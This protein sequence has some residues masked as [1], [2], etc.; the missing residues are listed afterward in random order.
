MGLAIGPVSC[1]MTHVRMYAILE[2][3]H[4]WCKLLTLSLE[5]QDELHFCCWLSTRTQMPVVQVMR[6]YVCS[7]CVAYG[8][9]TAE[10]HVA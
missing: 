2:S 4:A 6:G 5:A 9:W 7:P 8:Q 1:F 10:L 3:K